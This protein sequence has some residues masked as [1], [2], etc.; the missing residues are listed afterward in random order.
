M[1]DEASFSE[2]D[3]EDSDEEFE[4]ED[5]D[6]DDSDDDFDEES[7]ED[8]DEEDEESDEDGNCPY[9]DGGDECQHLFAM[10]ELENDIFESKWITEA[11]IKAILPDVIYEMEENG[12][13]EWFGN[14]NDAEKNALF[15]GTNMGRAAVLVEQLSE[16]E[17]FSVSAEEGYLA[18]L[19]EDCDQLLELRH[20]FFGGGAVNTAQYVNYWTDEPQQAL[21]WIRKE[22]KDDAE[23]LSIIASRFPK[24][25]EK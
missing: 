14:L 24:S 22:L 11:E 2:D 7:D 9:C 16:C 25:T 15:E 6:A 18:V 8:S 21:E 10:L 19:L 4:D 3:V 13:G 20:T 1:N 23:R 5:S 12:Y 17:G